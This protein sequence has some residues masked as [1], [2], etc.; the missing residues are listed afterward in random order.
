MSGLNR[1]ENITIHEH[2]M[3]NKSIMEVDSSSEDE[4]RYLTQPNSQESNLPFSQS[5]VVLEFEAVCQ[6]VNSQSEVSKTA[7]DIYFS[8][9]D[10]DDESFSNDDDEVSV[11][12]V[13]C[14]MTM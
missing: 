11:R 4:Y 10:D 3:D 12:S 13:D 14:A 1:P 8:S 5:N 6:P 9:D 7:V 2:N